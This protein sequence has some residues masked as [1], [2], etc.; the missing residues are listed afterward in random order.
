VKEHGMFFHRGILASASKTQPAGSKLSHTF[1]L[2]DV[3][4]RTWDVLSLGHYARPPVK[5]QK[6]KLQFKIQK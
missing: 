5:K 6:A 1:S 4:E 2:P 3:S